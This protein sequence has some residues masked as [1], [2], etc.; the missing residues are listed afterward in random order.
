MLDSVQYGR[1]GLSVSR[2][3]LGTMNFGEPGV[4][5]HG[6]WTLSLDNARPIFKAAMDQGLYYFDC[7]NNY[8]MGASERV[9]GALL[10]DLFP[11]ESYVLSTKLIMPMAKGPNR[12][13]LSRKHVMEEIDAILTRLGLDYVDQLVVHRHPSVIPNTPAAPLEEGLEALHDVVKA[14]K[15]L[16]I[17]ASSMYTWQFVQMRMISE[18][19]GWHKFISMQNHYNLIY[20]EEE[21]EMHP[22]CEAEGIAV[23]PW[24]PLA[25]GVLTGSYKGG[26]DKGAT[27]R[28]QGGDAERAMSL[29]RGDMEFDIVDRVAELAEKRGHS[30]AQIALAWMLSKPVI[31]SPVIGVSKIEQLEQ[32]IAATKITLSDDDI[33]YLEEL[34]RPVANILDDEKPRS[35]MVKK[36]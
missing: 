1:S 22:Y 25:R 14:G 9:V 36:D 2:L 23:T 15:A 21:R 32:L 5:Q 3:C 4:G 26:F 13:G 28:S 29:Y 16:Y 6:H 31:T 7:A 19:N 24:S 20:R 30:S 12:G 35:V 34:Y 33:A 17:G 8:G 11:R 18:R 27:K 10:R